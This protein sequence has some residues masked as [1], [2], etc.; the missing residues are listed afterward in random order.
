MYSSYLHL[1]SVFRIPPPSPCLFRPSPLIFFYSFEKMPT[2]KLNT[3][4]KAANPR[5]KA[6]L[7]NRA[8]YRLTPNQYVSAN[9]QSD[10]IRAKV[11]LLNVTENI[12]SFVD[13]TKA[14]IRSMGSEERQINKVC[15]KL[16]K[17]VNNFEATITSAL[18]GDNIPKLNTKDN[19]T[20]VLS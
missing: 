17:M 14:V 5:S 12:A 10:Q 2:I 3:V 4:T 7:G 1:P 11:K 18:K 16:L 9:P 6:N 19:S 8:I 15:P 13:D 20:Y